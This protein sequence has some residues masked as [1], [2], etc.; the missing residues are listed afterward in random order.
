MQETRLYFQ[1]RLSA[2][3]RTVPTANTVCGRQDC[4]FIKVTRLYFQETVSR[5][6]DCTYSRDYLQDKDYT[7]GKTVCRRQDSTFKGL[8]AGEKTV[9]K[10]GTVNK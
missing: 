9:L 1:Q 8:S 6:Q 7:L 10:A 2:G 5:K 3:N 4:T